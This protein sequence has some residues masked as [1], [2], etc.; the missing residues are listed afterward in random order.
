MRDIKHFF[1]K[2]WI[3]RW[4]Y[5]PIMISKAKR[6]IAHRQMIFQQNG[7]EL[8]L[9]FVECMAEHNITYW[10][11]FGTLLGV[12][13]DKA[14]IPNDIDLDVGTDLSNANSMYQAL[15]K[16]GFR[17]VREFHVVGENGLEQTYEYKGVTIDIMYFF[18]KE[19]YLWCNGVSLP[20]RRQWGKLTHAQVT[21]HWFTPFRTK[22]FECFGLDVLIPENTEQHLIEIFGDGYKIY[23]PDFPGDLNKIRYSIKEK[24][25]I[26]FVYY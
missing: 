15:T 25:A 11:E 22:T 8:L 1:K 23:D 24:V 21:A 26:G 4:I 7:L 2:T 5:N 10:L 14:F 9:K 16:S 3:Y 6:F 17:L 13:R 12:Y 19:G 18:L 20:A